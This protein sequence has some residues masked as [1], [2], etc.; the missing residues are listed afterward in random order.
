MHVRSPSSSRWVPAIL[1]QGISQIFDWVNMGA[2]IKTSTAISFLLAVT[3]SAAL[4]VCPFYASGESVLQVGGARIL[5]VL[6]LPVLVS[7]AP[8]LFPRRAVWIGSTAVLSLFVLAAG[9]S[10][11][12]FYAPCALLLV[13]GCFYRAGGDSPR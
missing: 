4:C 3:C 8:I 9:F 7:L 1:V 10:I 11:G 2:V 13:P 6:T 5:G 12:M